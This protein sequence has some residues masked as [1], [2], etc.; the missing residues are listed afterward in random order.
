MDL[1]ERPTFLCTR[2]SRM[3]REL[4]LYR[5]NFHQLRDLSPKPRPS[6]YL[7]APTAINE[8]RSGWQY[9]KRRYPNLEAAEAKLK[10]V[11]AKGAKPSSVPLGRN[12]KRYWERRPKSS[13]VKGKS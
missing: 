1:Q 13:S 2:S 12:L 6:D 10:E 3:R 5:N 7:S 8:K 4:H 11:L 9:L